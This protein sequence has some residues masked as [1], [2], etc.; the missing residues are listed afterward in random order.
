MVLMDYDNGLEAARSWWEETVSGGVR[1]FVSDISL[2][3]RY[4]G[5]AN[6]P[7]PREQRVREFEERIKTMRRESK[8]HRVLRIN[9]L[10]VR[11]AQKLLSDYCLN[12]TPPQHRGRMEA[13]ICDMLIAA[14]ALLK[15][16]PVVT[17]N[18][19]DFEW[20]GGLQVLRP[21]YEPE[22]SS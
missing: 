17:F 15:R 1:I 20:I 6:L 22:E 3:E 8:I 4:K 14:T 9:A 2:M 16:F 19:R 7:G 10:V 13:L 18:T 5:L 21:D 12:H 11:K